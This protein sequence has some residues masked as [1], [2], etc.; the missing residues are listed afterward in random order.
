LQICVS[1]FFYDILIYSPNWTIHLEHVK[2]AFEILRQHQFFIKLNKC[3]FGKEELEYVGHIVTS[4]VVKVDQVK[5]QTMLNWPRL[6]N[7]YELRGF[8]SLTG[9]YRKFVR[10]YNILNRSLTNLL[11]KGQFSWSEEA[12]ST[13]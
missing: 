8:L 7:I 11:K 3:A 10:D 12:E 4:H 13:L 6:T 1:L 5:I 9:Y 2:Q